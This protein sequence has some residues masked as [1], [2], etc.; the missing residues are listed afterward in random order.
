MRFNACTT[1][2]IVTNTESD[3]SQVLA[4]AVTGYLTNGDYASS[5][6]DPYGNTVTYETDVTKGLVESITDSKGTVTNYTYNADTDAL[7]R[8]EVRDSK[9]DY[10]YTNHKLTS[11][12][13]YVN[14]E[15]NVT[16]GFTYDVFENTDKVSV[17]NRILIDHTYAPYNGN[18]T[19]TTYGNG[20]YSENIY[21]EL[22]RVP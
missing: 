7:T 10:G 9:V 15:E 12:L 21:D 6:T 18:L 22:D 20:F 13:H 3:D 5:V 4:G 8:V 17:G 19:R 1:E 11:I 14:S 2:I 16:Y